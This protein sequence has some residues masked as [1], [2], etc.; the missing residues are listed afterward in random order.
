MNKL[1]IPK[2][3]RLQSADLR[4]KVS[5]VLRNH[6]WGK[7]KNPEE[8]NL[9]KLLEWLGLNYDP[10]NIHDRQEVYQKT[11]CYWRKHFV[12]VF[13]FWLD[14]GDIKGEDRFE[15]W[16]IA[17]ANYNKHD[18]Y[19]LFSRRERKNTYFIQPSFEEIEQMDHKRLNR[20]MKG[21]LTILTEMKLYDARLLPSK[22]EVTDML[23]DSKKFEQVY[24]KDGYGYKTKRLDIVKGEK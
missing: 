22:R 8:F 14:I 17:L 13:K 23:E 3:L 9:P 7:R 18:A 6:G 4:Y 19:V 1:A 2:E 16:E 24:L 15:K 10:D 12:P 11:I 21:I 5:T 20:Q